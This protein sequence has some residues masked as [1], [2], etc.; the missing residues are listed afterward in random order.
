MTDGV[1]AFQSL[2]VPPNASF[3]IAP[4][5]PGRYTYHCELHPIMRGILIV[6]PPQ[7]AG[8]SAVTSLP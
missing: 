4:L 8:V 1:C 6:L 3:M 2:A 5:L 7:L